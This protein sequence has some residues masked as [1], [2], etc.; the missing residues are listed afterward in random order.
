MG[1]PFKR[2]LHT[3]CVG[4][5][6]PKEGN[7]FVSDCPIAFTHR[8]PIGKNGRMQDNGTLLFRNVMAG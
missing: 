4:A 7:Y 6:P 5:T 2:N 8:Q 3:D 1:V